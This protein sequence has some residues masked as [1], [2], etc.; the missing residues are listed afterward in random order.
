MCTPKIIR[1]DKQWHLKG[2]QEPID[3]VIRCV[4]AKRGRAFLRRY[5]INS[6]ERIGFKSVNHARIADCDV[7]VLSRG[8]KKVT[9]DVPLKSASSR[10]FPERA[11]S[12]NSLSA[13]PTLKR[14]FVAGSK[15]CLVNFTGTSRTMF[16]FF[17]LATSSLHQA[18]SA[19]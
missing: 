3:F 15:P 6:L 10:I 5:C 19:S 8:I 17:S 7:K 4:K 12:A 11:S 1:Q 2:R 18:Y 13:P 16:Y 14:R 9:S